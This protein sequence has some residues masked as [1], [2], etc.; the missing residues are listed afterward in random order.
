MTTKTETQE[1]S[2]CMI[3]TT[4]TGKTALCNHELD[5]TALYRKETRMGGEIEMKAERD[6]TK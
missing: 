6:F 2:H 3:T 1:E 5:V 4:K